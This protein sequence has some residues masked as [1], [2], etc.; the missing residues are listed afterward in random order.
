ME[1]GPIQNEKDDLFGGSYR[2]DFNIMV[3]HVLFAMEYF[4]ISFK[5]ELL[6]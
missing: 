5:Y 6:L 1:V 4:L 3:Y 2:V